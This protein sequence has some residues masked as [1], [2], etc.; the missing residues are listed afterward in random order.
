MISRFEDDGLDLDPAGVPQRPLVVIDLDRY[1]NE[2]PAAVAAAADRVERALPLVVGVLRGPAVAPL[3]PLLTAITL[4][5]TDRQASALWPQM[6][7]VADLD[8]ALA[9]LHAV[10]AYAPRA[11]VACGQLLRQTVRLPT[12]PALA[13]EAAV[14]SMLL[15]GP[16]FARW[17]AERGPAREVARPAADLVRVDREDDR[18]DIVLDHPQR[19]NALSMRLREQLLAALT[20]AEAD[21][22]IGAVTLRGNGPA[23]C[24]GGDLDEFGTATDLVAAYLVRVDRAPWRII[25]QLADRVTARIHGPCIGAGAEMAAF[26]GTVIAAPGTVLRLPEIRMGLVPGAGGTVSIPRRIG[27]W[28]AAWLMLTGTPL[29]AAAAL[30]WGLVDRLEDN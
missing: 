30:R 17:L 25:D 8:A 27:R 22:T 13:A 11:A 5:L 18:L 10:T 29:P 1:A 14:Y 3:R 23:F 28:R 7:A 9:E 6:V 24:S 21:P 19:R 12:T 15:G 20:V 4:T 26:A 16:E 2:S